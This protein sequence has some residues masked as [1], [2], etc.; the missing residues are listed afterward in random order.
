MR[1]DVMMIKLNLKLVWA[2]QLLN[3][4]Q[5][6]ALPSKCGHG[7]RKNQLPGQTKCTFD[8]HGTDMKPWG[9]LTKDL[10]PKGKYPF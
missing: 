4:C 1:F 5:S 2:L 6:G 9:L 7:G 10:F 3:L 8:R